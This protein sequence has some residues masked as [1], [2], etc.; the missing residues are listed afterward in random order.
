LLL[1]EP[2]AHLDAVLRN[3]LLEQLRELTGRRGLTS[4]YVTHAWQEAASL[5]PRIGVLQQGRL[6]QAA[7]AEELYWRPVNQSVARLTGPVLTVPR[8]WLAEGRMAPDSQAPHWD[9]LISGTGELL[10]L[11]P[12]QVH[13]VPPQEANRWQVTDCRP[14]GT[15][16]RVE[17][18]GEAGRRL[19][20]PVGTATAKG[21]W[22]GLEI[23]TMGS[24][25]AGTST[26]GVLGERD[27][28]GQ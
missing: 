28:A 27:D 22:I 6:E 7:T 4:L 23:C 3:E 24:R 14:M 10:W 11:R 16:W 2:L 19:V 25:A 20:L 13:M 5:C 12:Q 18:E 1:D 8:A 26:A 17:L 9:G 15:G 21:A